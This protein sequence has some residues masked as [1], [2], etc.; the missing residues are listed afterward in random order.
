MANSI[1]VTKVD[2]ESRFLLP[3]DAAYGKELLMEFVGEIVPQPYDPALFAY[4][5]A[6]AIAV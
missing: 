3:L 5:S 4:A 1:V 2:V 6:N